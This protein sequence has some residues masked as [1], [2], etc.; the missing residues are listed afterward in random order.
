MLEIEGADKG[1]PAPCPFE[2]DSPVQ[3]PDSIFK[4]PGKTFPLSV[5]AGLR[6]S[7]IRMAT[8]R[9][10]RRLFAERGARCLDVVHALGPILLRHLELGIAERVAQGDEHTLRMLLLEFRLDHR[11]ALL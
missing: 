2:N 9:S 10:L 5:M 1:I 11:D 3:M 6:P 4:Q 7:P 8:T